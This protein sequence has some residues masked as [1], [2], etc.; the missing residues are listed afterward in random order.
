MP[1]HIEVHLN[2]PVQ[3]LSSCLRNALQF[4]L[5]YRRHH[6]NV[7][8]LNCMSYRRTF[9]VSPSRGRTWELFSEPAI[10]NCFRNWIYWIENSWMHIGVPNHWYLVKLI[11]KP[12]CLLAVQGAA[13]YNKATIFVILSHQKICAKEQPQ[14]VLSRKC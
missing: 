2:Y 8:S 13:V 7:I 1:F 9:G 6:K 12:Q 11:A 3:I 5:I 10:A 4:I 14:P